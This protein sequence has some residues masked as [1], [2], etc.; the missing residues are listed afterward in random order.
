MNEFFCF[1]GKNII[2]N[3]SMIILTKGGIHKNY[4]CINCELSVN[5]FILKINMNYITKNAK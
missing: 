3:S 4:F 5:D 1:C 2:S